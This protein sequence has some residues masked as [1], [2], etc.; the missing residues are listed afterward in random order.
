MFTTR[1][2][3]R[4]H[5][6]NDT[7]DVSRDLW[8]T[9]V[10]ISARAENVE[11]NQYQFGGASIRITQCACDAHRI[12]RDENTCEHQSNDRYSKSNNLPEIHE[13]P[14]NEARPKPETEAATKMVTPSNSPQHECDRQTTETLYAVSG[15]GAP[16]E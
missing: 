6:S 12:E 1:E 9:L 4:E 2:L 8:I 15:K 5:Q 14:A 11:S 7:A 3:A 13:R 16:E 10:G